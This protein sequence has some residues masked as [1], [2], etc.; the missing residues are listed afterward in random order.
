MLP[1]LKNYPHTKEAI[2]NLEWDIKRSRFD[3]V[4]WQPGGDLFEQNNIEMATKNQTR[5]NDEITSMKGQIEDKKK[6]IRKLKL[7]D[8]FKGLENQ[9]I[10]MRYID[11]MSLAELIRMIKFAVKNNGDPVELD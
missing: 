7:I 6:E 1:Q 11:G 8:I 3:L 9:V 4:R 2:S 10:R 5:L